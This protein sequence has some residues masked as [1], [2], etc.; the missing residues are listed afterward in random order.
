MAKGAATNRSI[1]AKRDGFMSTWFCYSVLIGTS[2][3]IDLTKYN[4]NAYNCGWRL[5]QFIPD[6][7]SA[8]AYSTNF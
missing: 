8:T 1:L 5:I 4:V 2:A 6:S 7:R 3:G